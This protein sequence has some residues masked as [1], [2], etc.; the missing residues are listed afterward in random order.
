MAHPINELKQKSL[1]AK[2]ALNAL[3]EKL[4]S[5]KA[6]VAGLLEAQLAA[7]TVAAAESREAVAQ[8][9]REIKATEDEAAGRRLLIATLEEQLHAA[10][11]LTASE[12]ATLPGI[13][14]K[15]HNSA[16]DPRRG[17]RSTRECM[18]AVMANAGARDRSQVSDER[19][20]GL[21]VLDR[22]DKMAAGELAFLLPVGFTPRQFLATVGSD[23]QGVYDDRYG[24]FTVG[25]TV[26]P[27]LLSVGFEGD[28]T[29]GRTTMVPMATPI[30]EWAARADKSHSTSVSGGF[31]VGRRAEAVAAAASRMTGIR[32]VL[33]VKTAGR[34]A[35]RK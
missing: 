26:M 22:D 1:T 15:P 2:A 8:A 20:K 12:D 5:G 28:P 7:G 30:V 17:F 31:T 3:L 14:V 19:L 24:G 4:S 11:Q 35:P 18:L 34:S 13:E 16:A 27:G 6:Q 32:S 25:K 29:V 23:E 33:C 10:E 21:A 9:Q